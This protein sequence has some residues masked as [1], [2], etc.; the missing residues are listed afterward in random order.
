M[1]SGEKR[2]GP[3]GRML[4]KAIAI[5]E[6]RGAAEQQRPGK[7]EDSEERTELRRERAERRRRRIG[8]DPAVLVLGMAV[9]V[10]G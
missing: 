3:A 9:V 1:N 7:Y 10:M 4:A 5:H 2:R 6:V 8:T